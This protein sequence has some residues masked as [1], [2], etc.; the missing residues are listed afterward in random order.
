MHEKKINEFSQWTA[1]VK[2]DDGLE[3]SIHFVGIFSNDKDAIPLVLLHGW[4]G[5]SSQSIKKYA[6]NVI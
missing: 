6:I 4:P 2:D 3:Y 1:L 5:R